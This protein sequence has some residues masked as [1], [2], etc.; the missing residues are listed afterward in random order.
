M[1][2]EFTEQ[3]NHLDKLN[4]FHAQLETQYSWRTDF[5]NSTLSSVFNIK[6]HLI[7]VTYLSMVKCYLAKFS[8]KNRTAWEEV[9]LKIGL[10]KQAVINSNNEVEKKTL[11]GSLQQRFFVS[12]L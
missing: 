7:T 10:I 12:S 1:F 11:S 9:G 3:I 6:A 4:R 5:Q 8:N 2:N